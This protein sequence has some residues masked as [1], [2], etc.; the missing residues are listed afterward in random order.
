MESQLD[1]RFFRGRSMAGTFRP[2]DRL[3]VVPSPLADLCPGDVV[4]YRALDE[5]GKDDEVAHRIVSRTPAGLIVRGDGNS[6]ADA[7][8]VTAT[9]LVGKVTLYERDGRTWRVQGG[10]RGL[11]HL[12][13]LSC[14]RR[15]WRL[16]GRVG[17]GP[18]RW[19]RESGLAAR[20]WRPRL[21]RVRVATNEGPLVKFVRGT[22]TVGKWWP[23]RDRWWCR[24]PYDLVLRREEMVRRY[25]WRECAPPAD[26]RPGSERDWTNGA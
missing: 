12:R 18:Y 19:L 20:I 13:V 7:T 24:K 17:R 6:S 23:E 16:V 14:R 21:I 11:L 2:G 26:A 1:C 3:T 25:G 22:K 10:R 15:V 4:I 5:Q 8:T 9:N